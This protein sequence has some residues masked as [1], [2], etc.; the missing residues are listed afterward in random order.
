MCACGRWGVATTIEQT[1]HYWEKNHLVL[2]ANMTI[3]WLPRPSSSAPETTTS[4][5]CILAYPRPENHDTD[6]DDEAETAR[7]TVEVLEE[8][9]QRLQHKLAFMEDTLLTEHQKRFGLTSVV[10]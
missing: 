4:P 5:P 7:L 8:A 10:D 2:Q 3:P 1:N 6:T 9:V